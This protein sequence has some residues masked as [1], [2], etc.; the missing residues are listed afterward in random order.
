MT[1]VYIITGVLTIMWLVRLLHQANVI[2]T[3]HGSLLAIADT[4]VDDPFGRNQ[5]L[6]Q[7][8]FMG[9]LHFPTDATRVTAIITMIDV[10]NAH[11]RLPVKSFREDLTN[12]DGDC[13]IVCHID[14]PNGNYVFRRHN[15]CTIPINDLLAPYSGSRRYEIRISFSSSTDVPALRE[16][17]TTVTIPP[18]RYGYLELQSFVERQRPSQ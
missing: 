1:F 9:S 17:E 14:I 18:P 10:T 7:I 4:R 3:T 6:L 5:T 2:T 13:C 16:A 8:G 15:L 11:D 12:G